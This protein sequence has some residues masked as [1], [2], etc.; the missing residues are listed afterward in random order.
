MTAKTKFKSNGILAYHELIE[1]LFPDDGPDLM[2]PKVTSF[3]MDNGMVGYY[4]CPYIP[5]CLE[6][7]AVPDV[8][9]EHA[10]EEINKSRKVVGP[11][12]LVFAMKSEYNP[13]YGSVGHPGPLGVPGIAMGPIPIQPQ[14]KTIN[15]GY[16]VVEQPDIVV[17]TNNTKI[18]DAAQVV[19]KFGKDST[20]SSEKAAEKILYELNPGNCSSRDSFEAA[21]PK[22]QELVKAYRK[23]AGLEETT[24]A[25]VDIARPYDLIKPNFD[26]SG[27]NLNFKH[28]MNP[29]PPSF[30]VG[31]FGGA[32]LNPAHHVGDVVQSSPTLGLPDKTWLWCDGLYVYYDDYPDL[33]N[34]LQFKN[35]N[36]FMVPG[37]SYIFKEMIESFTGKTKFILPFITGYMI[38]ALP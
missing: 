29:L 23:G 3:K 36:Y 33:Y 2:K 16:T 38:K 20:L 30:G 12:G 18:E 37:V 10:G 17:M 22:I 11:T 26:L 7:L 27:L 13:R 14:I 31:G 32:V 21:I 6:H 1:K 5:K 34:F 24:R 15:P 8:K 19:C 35:G 28:L 9:F 25:I 4:Y